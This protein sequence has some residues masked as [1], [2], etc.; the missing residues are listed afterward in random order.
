MSL[1]ILM[2]TVMCVDCKSTES[3]FWHKCSGGALCTTCYCRRDGLNRSTR[4]QALSSSCLTSASKVAVE[5]CSSENV[6]LVVKSGS[7]NM[8]RKSN[9]LKPFSKSR[10]WQNVVKPSST[11]GRSKRYIFKKNVIISCYCKRTS[12][13]YL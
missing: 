12:L 8:P 9:R 5:P 2:Q 4:S 13:K 10:L 11:K 3:S 6:G 1:D 7:S